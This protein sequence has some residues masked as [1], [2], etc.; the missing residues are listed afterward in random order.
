MF[1]LLMSLCAIAGL[2]EMIQI[3]SKFGDFSVSKPR[4][5][6]HYVLSVSNSKLSA[7]P[8]ASDEVIKIFCHLAGLIVFWFVV[9]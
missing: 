3:K 1:L 8:L 2:P 7:T 9:G 4:K 6:I 5:N